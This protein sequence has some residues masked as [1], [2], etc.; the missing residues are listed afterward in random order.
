[1]NRRD[2]LKI[3]GSATIVATLTGT[4]QARGK[5]Q[6][7]IL[8]V[9]TDQQFAN[10]MSCVMGEKYIHTPNI[11]SIAADGMR[12]TR[13]YCSNP[14]CVPSRSSMFTGRFPHKHGKQTNAT[15][16]SLDTGEFPTMGTVLRRAGYATGYCG[17]WHLP[18][19]KDVQEGGFEMTSHLG[20][21]GND[22]KIAA[23]AIQFI[24]QNRDKP[25]FLV[26]S[27]VNPHNICQYGRSQS[28]PDGDVGTPPALE[29][30]PPAPE[31]LEKATN[32]SD[33]LEALWQARLR[34]VWTGGGRM[35][36]PLN[37]WT[38][39]D[40]RRYRWAY[41]RMIE[42]V[43][44]EM[45]KI[46]SALRD[47][48]L[49]RNTV[50]IFTA[51]HGDGMGSHRWAQKNMFYDEC[52]RI[53]LIISRKGATK[54]GTSD[55]LASNGIDLMPTVCDYAGAELPPGCKGLS[56]RPLAEGKTVTKRRSYITCSTHFVQDLR[57]DG[58]PIDMQGRMIRTEHFKYYIF[59]KGRQPETLIDMDND[60]SEM[61]NLAADPALKD[62]LSQ[63]RSYLR[64]YAAETGDEF[65]LT[66]LGPGV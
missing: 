5:S 57:E 24:E 4:L 32:Q 21:S 37:K 15:K 6:P 26:C 41:Y 64:R 58:E 51:D 45:G 10:G 52:S 38:A 65:A 20:G 43:D 8:L 66:L 12:F 17:K 14:L 50:I 56:L 3:I 35:F 40:W 2:F 44:H 49:E 19:A 42:L 54:P 34:A 33:S 29:Q 62:V 7:N 18:Y 16:P 31:N 13:A 46:L 1:M 61:V 11:D 9:M 28:L 36:A 60:P 22:P 25:F 27:F 63:H 48:G 39:D 47:A 55:Y 53:P 23:P 59:D 30:C